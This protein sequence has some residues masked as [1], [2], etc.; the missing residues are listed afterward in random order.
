MLI[1]VSEEIGLQLKQ[2][3][4]ERE[5]TIEELVS[6]MLD[7]YDIKRNS[8]TLAELAA[9]AEKADLATAHPVDTSARSREILNTEYADY[10][11]QRRT[12]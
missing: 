11:N 10:L 4:N 3:A 2:L 12:T 6:A 9:N 1:E 8:V 7:Q 5:L